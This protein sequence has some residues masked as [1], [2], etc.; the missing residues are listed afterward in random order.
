MADTKP[1]G[2]A[3]KAEPVEPAE[4]QEMPAIVGATFAERSAAS[5]ADTKQ[6]APDDAENKAVKSASTKRARKKS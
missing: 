5:K 3:P 4:A 6:V 1:N 2:A